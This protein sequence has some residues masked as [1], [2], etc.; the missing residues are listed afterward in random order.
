MSKYSRTLGDFKTYQHTAHP[1]TNT[2]SHLPHHHHPCHQ[3]SSLHHPQ[4][5]SPAHYAPQIPPKPPPPPKKLLVS[6]LGGGL[7]TETGILYEISTNSFSW[8]GLKKFS[9]TPQ[10]IVSVCFGGSKKLKLAYCMKY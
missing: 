2:T 4:H 9:Y 7:K 10:K 6:V 8:G 5:P 3:P 1:T